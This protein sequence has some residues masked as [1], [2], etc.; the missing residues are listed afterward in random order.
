[1]TASCSIVCYKNTP[2]QIVRLLESI[3]SSG[4][5]MQIYLVDNSKTAGLAG[6]A[7]QFGARYLHLPRNPGYG[8]GHNAAIREA[9]RAGSQYHAVMNPDIHFGA[10]VLPTL[11]D[12]MACNPDIGLLAPRVQYPDGRPQYLC[13]LLPNPI[14]ML[15]RRFL[16]ALHRH[17]GRQAHYELRDSGYDR[18]MNVPVLSGCFMLVRTSLLPLAGLFDERFFMYFEDVDLSRRIGAVAR[19]VYYPHVRIVHE[20][21]KGSYRNTTLLRHHLRSAISY[22]NKWGWFADADRASI[23]SLARETPVIPVP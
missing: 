9:L 7:R 13:K 6:I 3:R 19:T 12:Y 15:V 1:M 23:N 16:P 5:P 8:S 17:S 11:V 20:Y 4:M 22:F 14:D 21:A 18:V 10:E 2:R